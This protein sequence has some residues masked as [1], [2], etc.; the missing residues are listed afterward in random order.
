MMSKIKAEEFERVISN[1]NHSWL[2]QE[3]HPIRLT[4]LFVFALLFFSSFVS[5]KLQE[6]V[7]CS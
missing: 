7:P 2:S 6:A 5:A 4:L 3:Y 1:K